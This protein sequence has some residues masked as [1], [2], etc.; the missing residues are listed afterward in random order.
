MIDDFS[1]LVIFNII[2]VILLIFSLIS[3]KKK[4]NYFA[5][6]ITTIMWGLIPWPFLYLNETVKSILMVSFIRI[7][8]SIIGAFIFIFI[9]VVL[10][11]FYNK[12][13]K[14]SWFQYSFQDFKKQIT[15]YL[16]SSRTSI[17]K[18]KSRIPYLFY[19]FLLGIFYVVS[20]Y[21]YF[22]AYQILGII[23]SSI[24][25][26]VAS[27][28]FVALWNLSRRLEYMDSIKFSYLSLF[29]IAGVLTIM[30]TPLTINNEASIFGFIALGMTL[31]FWVLFIITSGLDDFTAY[32]KER[33]VSFRDKNTNFQ[34]TKS[35]VKIF[36]FFISSLLGLILFALVIEILP[37]ENSTIG[38]E[39]KNFL[40]E[41][42][43][44]PV[45]IFN[46]WTW[47]LG[48]E[49]TIIPYI[50]YF[51]SQ[52]V[53]LRNRRSLKWDQWVAILA[54]FEPFTTIF[55]GFFIG[56]EGVRFDLTL[57][58]M[59][60]I[61]LSI[62]MLLRYYH[63]KNSLRSIILLKIKPKKWKFLIDRLKYNP[64]IRELKSITG[65]YDLLLKTFFQSNYLLRN[66][67]AE[68]KKFDS[69]LEME[70]F[71]EFDV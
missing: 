41:F 42:Q 28:I 58:T 34:L 3:I 35:L 62:T 40:I 32:E 36:F 43:N 44:F 33:I 63:E 11:S 18:R 27:M 25:N 37:L 13:G 9:S 29:I 24:L 66:F 1:S 26:T 4:V 71:I 50:V 38:I 67:I 20:I 57:L 61:I 52:S 12:K 45:I 60:V 16:P 69:I 39:I 49:S 53:S 5:I 17:T 31:I 65:K 30:S 6:L 19:Y 54:V 10:T 48:I 59:A 14:W 15:S 2:T 56:N 55:V 70:N 64:N 21:F 46:I 47:V 22:Q 8:L 68:L 23:F 51:S 7:L